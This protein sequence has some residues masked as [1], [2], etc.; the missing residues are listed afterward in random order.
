MFENDVVLEWHTIL[1]KINIFKKLK[2]FK[3]MS[4]IHF[5][6]SSCNLYIYHYTIHYIS[7]THRKI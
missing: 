2:R 3:I 1:C 6:G 7:V 4:D 5:K